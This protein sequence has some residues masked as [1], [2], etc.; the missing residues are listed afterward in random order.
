MGKVIGGVVAVLGLLIAVLTWL[1][2]D[3]LAIN[4]KVEQPPGNNAPNQQPPQGN[5][6]PNIEISPKSGPPGSRVTVTGTGFPANAEVEIQFHLDSVGET[7]SD[8]NGAF[9]ITVRIPTN[10]PTKDFP[11]G[12]I[13][14]ATPYSDREDFRVT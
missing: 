3:P 1:F 12:I 9:S 7:R 11:W 13:A 4:D 14:T 5:L 10:I 6:R 2:P 8:A